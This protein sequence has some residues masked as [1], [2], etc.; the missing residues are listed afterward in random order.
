MLSGI[1]FVGSLT[2]HTLYLIAML[3]LVSVDYSQ[4]SF[5]YQ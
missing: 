2:I 1:E 4:F 3:G 5:V